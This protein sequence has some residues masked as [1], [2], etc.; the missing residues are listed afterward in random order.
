ML[1]FLLQITTLIC[2]FYHKRT[3]TVSLG[4]SYSYWWHLCDHQHGSMASHNSRKPIVG[5]M[6]MKKKTSVSGCIL[7]LYPIWNRDTVVTSLCVSKKYCY[8][9]FLINMSIGAQL[10]YYNVHGSPIPKMYYKLLIYSS[11]LMLLLR[12]QSFSFGSLTLYLSSLHRT[13]TQS[14]IQDDAFERADQILQFLHYQHS[15]VVSNL[16]WKLH[17]V[18]S[19][20]KRNLS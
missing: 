13:L 20:A 2:C 3:Q 19:H 8:L 10:P 12:L 4:T 7:R 5:S 1:F 11:M 15:N 17:T 9:P 18:I 14:Q 16:F 6:T